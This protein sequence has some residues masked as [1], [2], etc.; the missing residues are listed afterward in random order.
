MANNFSTGVEGIIYTSN[1]SSISSWNITPPQ[2]I[3]AFVGISSQNVVA[4]SPGGLLAGQTI[5]YTLQAPIPAPLWYFATVNQGDS[6][7][8]LTTMNI[9]I[10]TSQVTPALG[11]VGFNNSYFQP[12]PGQKFNI[13]YQA[14]AVVAAGGPA[15]YIQCIVEN[16]ISQYIDMSSIHFNHSPLAAEKAA[17]KGIAYIPPK[18]EFLV[19]QN[20]TSAID[21][22]IA[23]DYVDYPLPDS[24]SSLVSFRGLINVMA[25]VS[26]GGIG[27]VASNSSS[28]QYQVVGGQS[29]FIAYAGGPMQT[30][31]G[32]VFIYL[33]N[34]GNTG[35][36]ATV[37]VPS[38][39]SIFDETVF[40]PGV[41][42]SNNVTSANAASISETV[43]EELAVLK[44]ML[45][46]RPLAIKCDESAVATYESGSTVQLTANVNAL[47]RCCTTMAKTIETLKHENSAAHARQEAKLADIF[48]HLHITNSLENELDSGLE[49]YLKGRE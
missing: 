31:T 39:P 33:T 11:G 5:V 27:S 2:N 15:F 38:M 35:A 13:I 12:N 40:T 1:S 32:R 29:G 42:T 20:T 36:P 22:T 3:T 43:R 23:I 46:D 30:F 24:V 44:S 16:T 7:T 28:T 10:I 47:A 48:A 45:G 26:Y 21:N 25:M 18:I 19:T 6:L 9:P 17:R 8:I 14:G 37:F 41:N 34:I 4:T 49:S